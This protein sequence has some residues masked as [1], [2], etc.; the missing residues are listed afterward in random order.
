MP[1]AAAIPAATTPAPY[2]PPIAIKV[3]AAALEVLVEDAVGV[4]A[5][6]A[7]DEVGV[8]VAEELLLDETTATNA[9]ELVW[10]QLASSSD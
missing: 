3:A 8:A 9:L 1:K 10:P 5:P 6:E 7:P 4:D 2:S